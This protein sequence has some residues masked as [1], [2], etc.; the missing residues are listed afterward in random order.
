MI[1]TKAALRLPILARRLALTAEFVEDGGVAFADRLA[2]S[3]LW[4]ASRSPC[5]YVSTKG[6]ASTRVILERLFAAGRTVI[7]P[8][9]EGD[10]VSLRRVSGFDELL[11]GRFGIP[12]PSAVAPLV[13]PDEPDLFVVPGVVFDREGRRIGFGKGYYDRLLSRSRAPAVGLAYCFQLVP[14]VPEEIH[15]RRMDF[16]H[17]PEETVACR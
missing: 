14:E 5:V 13:S 10:E 1:S 8:R 6:E 2:A 11:P 16:I 15:D 4:R 9:V 17:T 7:V 3:E 12:E